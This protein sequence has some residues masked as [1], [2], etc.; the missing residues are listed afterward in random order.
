MEPWFSVCHAR[1]PA[2]TSCSQVPAPVADLRHV[3]AMLAD[4]ELVTLH[5]RPVTRRRLLHLIAEPWNSLDG[6]QRELVAVEI[7][8]HDHVEGGRS[9]ALLLVTA[10][11]NIVMIVPPVGQLVN[12]RG[13]AMKSEDHRLVCREQFVKILIFQTMGMFGLRLQYHQIHHVDD[14]D[15]DVGDIRAQ[16]GH[17]ASVSRVGTSPAQATTT[18]GSPTSLLAHRQI[19]APTVQWLTAGSMAS[20]C[21][22]GCLPAMMTL[23]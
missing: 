16:E 8:Q 13:I 12:H 19:P 1:I 7:V 6:V 10:H 14:A 15:A 5:G 20:H 3:I 9:G 22:S 18:S 4:I 23:M 2:E 21:H 17:E 11:M